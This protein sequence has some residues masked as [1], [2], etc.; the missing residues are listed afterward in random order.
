[1]HDAQRLVYELWRTADVV[2]VRREN[3]LCGLPLF[4]F[5][6]SPAITYT[7]PKLATVYC[8]FNCQSTITSFPCEP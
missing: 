6:T 2:R 8:F 1:M 5:I 3:P 4:K 7:H